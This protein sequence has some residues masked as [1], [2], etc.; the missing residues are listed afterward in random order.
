VF[1]PEAKRSVWLVIDGEDL[2]VDRNGNGDLTE[3]GKRMI[4]KPAFQ[5]G[6]F[7]V[8]EL[9]IGEHKDTYANLM[10]YWTQQPPGRA[11][12]E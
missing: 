10:V 9:A 8:P 3:K 4:R 11:T 6:G 2:Y 5:G 1:G 7:E 12:K